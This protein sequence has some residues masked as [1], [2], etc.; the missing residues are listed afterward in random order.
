MSLTL[1]SSDDEDNRGLTMNDSDSNSDLD[2]NQK[3]VNLPTTLPALTV[4]NLTATYFTA[5]L[6]LISPQGT[7]GGVNFTYNQFSLKHVIKSIYQQMLV[8][9]SDP[10]I[11]SLVVNPNG[12]VAIGSNLEIQNN[13]TMNGIMTAPTAVIG[14]VKSGVKNDYPDATTLI[15]FIMDINQNK[16]YLVNVDGNILLTDSSLNGYDI[17]VKNTSVIAVI[18]TSSPGAIAVAP[19]STIHLLHTSG[20]WIQL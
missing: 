8:F 9:Q 6:N 13:L 12:D 5:Q 10:N 19:N 4:D 3:L 7:I 20:S 18:V 14:N 2:S 1:I 17:F 15:S 16:F 11:D